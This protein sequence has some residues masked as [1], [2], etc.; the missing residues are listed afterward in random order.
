MLSPPIKSQLNPV[1]RTAIEHDQGPLLILAGAG[2]GKTRVITERMI[3]LIRDGLAAP[4]N[5]AALTFTNKAAAEMRSRVEENL[6]ERGKRVCIRTFHSLALAILRRHGE[7][8]GLVPN[9]SIADRSI[10]KSLIKKI[11]KELR[12]DSKQFEPNRILFHID[13]ARDQLLTPDQY[14]KNYQILCHK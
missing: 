8:I 10:Q 3:R 6:G 1:Q 4:W 7:Q 2:S 9:F 5:I 14:L 11:L 13:R 12:V